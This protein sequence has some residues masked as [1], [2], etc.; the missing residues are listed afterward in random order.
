AARDVAC[1]RFR[2]IDT[3]QVCA[4][5][6]MRHTQKET[7]ASSV[8]H[9]VLWITVAG[10]AIAIPLYVSSHAE[11]TFRLPKE[12]LLRAEAVA[13]ASSIVI[14]A[15]WQKLKLRSLF[16]DRVTGMVLA[17]CAVAAASSTALSANRATSVRS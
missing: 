2:I 12:L 11:D 10:F 13:A 17:V 15:I 4:A 14:A 9:R 6:M 3:R 16:F 1:K 8:L 7:G 5:A